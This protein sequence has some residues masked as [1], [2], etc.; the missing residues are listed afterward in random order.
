L[1]GVFHG[2]FSVESW[3]LSQSYYLGSIN[4]NPS[5]RCEIIPGTPID[6]LDALDETWIGR[7]ASKEGTAEQQGKVRPTRSAN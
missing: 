4:H 2:I 5:H 3:T 7:P 1:N 6:L